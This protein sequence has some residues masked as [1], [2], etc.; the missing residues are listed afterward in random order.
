MTPQ[1]DRPRCSLKH[2]LT[3]TVI[4][5]IVGV[6]TFFVE[7]A[8]VNAGATDIARAINVSWKLALI[9]AFAAV[10]FNALPWCRGYYGLIIGVS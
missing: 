10:I 9:A 7:K 4:L 8:A 3:L 1:D 5:L 6:V 2:S